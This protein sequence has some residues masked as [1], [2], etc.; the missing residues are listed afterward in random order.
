MPQAAPPPPLVQI[1]VP[2]PRRYHRARIRI[3]LI[4]VLIFCALPFLNIIRFDIP[5]QRFYFAGFELWINEFGILFFALMFLMFVIAAVSMIYGRLYCAYACPQMI[6]GE[7]ASRAEDR[8]KRYVTKRWIGLAAPARAWL[9]R[10]IFYSLLMGAS[11]FL[12]F[13]F[14]SYFVDPVDLLQRLVRFDI[15][16]AGG[17]AGAATTLLTFF[18]F[19]F[20]R[21]RFCT[22]VCPYGYL[23][24]MLADSQTLLI[25]YDDPNHVCIECK[26]CLRVCHMGIDIRHS[27]FQIECIHCGEC[28]EA[29]DEI[30]ARLRKPGLIHYTWGEKGETV[31]AGGK[32]W[33]YRLGLRDAKRG[34]VLAVLAFYASGL[35]IALSMRHAVLVRISPDRATLYSI[36]AGG[37]VVNKFRA[38][39]S[40]RGKKNAAVMFRL[41]GIRGA[42]IR[43]PENPLSV[44]AGRTVQADFE[45]EAA[46]DPAAY[47]VH[48]QFVARSSDG[49]VETIPMTFLMP[50]KGAK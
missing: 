15:Q 45:V 3:H 16:T 11:V 13:V 50:Q 4:C 18:D 21:Q 17:I 20:V 40:N 7:A 29:C 27:P 8:I 48:F 49:S 30:L 5:K 38:S 28:I 43:M 37:T 25:R 19:A 46:P 23:Q 26:K 44:P 2:P 42:N 14:I 22:S 39:V 10:G 35:L 41:D 9:A 31:G 1:G 6:F 47:V 12:A 24:G 34:V 36:Q 32:P 33:W